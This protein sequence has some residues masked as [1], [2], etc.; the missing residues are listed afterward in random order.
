[1]NRFACRAFL[2]S[3]LLTATA[4]AQAAELTVVLQDVRAQTGLI[5]V[6]LVDSQAGWDGQAA[7][8]QATG[9][10]P[11]GEQATFV[12]KD[13]K[14]GAYAVLITH[15]ENGNGQLDT[16]MMG[17]PVEGYGFSNNPRVMRKPTW[18][19]ARFELAGEATRIDVAL[20]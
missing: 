7:P 3:A 16:N 13:L 12:F 1:M 5:K 6:A 10:P 18:D 4:G 8:V 2:L 20:R 17:M 15:D 19:E 9:A 11:S 14:P